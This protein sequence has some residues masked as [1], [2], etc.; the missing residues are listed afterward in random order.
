M[1]NLPCVLLIDDETEFQ[2]AFAESLKA[3]TRKKL[4][5]LE[6]AS[7]GRQGLKIITDNNKQGRKTFAFIDIILPDLQGDKLVAEIGKNNN[8]TKGILISAHKSNSELEKI[9]NKYDWLIDSIPKP[10]DKDKLKNAVN[11][12]IGNPNLS[13][14]NYA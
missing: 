14:F 11:S 4:F 8:D 2:V 6:L 5:R 9:R 13:V 7:S 12:F 10:L 3:E 1:K